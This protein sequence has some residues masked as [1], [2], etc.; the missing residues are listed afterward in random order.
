MI[1]YSS[2]KFKSFFQF[3]FINDVWPNI[4]MMASENEIQVQDF[5]FWGLS[6]REIMISDDFVII[7]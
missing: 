4:D 3:L 6:L 1:R 5:A 7:F 2:L